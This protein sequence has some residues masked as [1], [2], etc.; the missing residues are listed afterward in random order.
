MKK[1]TLA[2]QIMI[3]GKKTHRCFDSFIAEKCTDLLRPDAGRILGYLSMCQK[4]STQEL[5]ERF[6]LSKASLSECL[7]LLKDRGLIDYRKSEA[8]GR[9]KVVELTPL[10]AARAE[11]FHQLVLSFNGKITEN[12]TDEEIKTLSQLLDKV[13]KQVEVMSYGE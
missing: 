8:D 7:T 2:T 1:Q 11:M 6:G 13:Q 9:E 10:G 12:L 5:Q 4:A 3:T